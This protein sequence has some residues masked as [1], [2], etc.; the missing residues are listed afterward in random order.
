MTTNTFV[1]RNSYING[2]EYNGA[3]SITTQGKYWN[4]SGHDT[5]VQPQYTEK[6]LLY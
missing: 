6:H 3:G 1:Y 5:S 2:W 4:I